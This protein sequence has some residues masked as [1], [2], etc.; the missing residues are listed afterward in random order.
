MQH[1]FAASA[2]PL[3]PPL[4]ENV[5]TLVAIGFDRSDALQALA[6]A[7]NDITTATN[8]LLESQFR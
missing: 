8:L 2:P 7:R 1:R 3:T 4:E 5:A 6:V